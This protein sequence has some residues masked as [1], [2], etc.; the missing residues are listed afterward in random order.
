M[1]KALKN[2]FS[3]SK[4]K[5]T[6]VNVRPKLEGLESRETPASVGY[7]GALNFGNVTGQRFVSSGVR[8]AGSQNAVLRYE[9]E[10]PVVKYNQFLSAE[11]NYQNRLNAVQESQPVV[12]KVTPASTLSPQQA[13]L[14]SLARLRGW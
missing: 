9:Q 10:Q 13:R 2:L 1:F 3:G 7:S 8:V 6:V 11:Q 4:A 14:Q 12:Q 5:K